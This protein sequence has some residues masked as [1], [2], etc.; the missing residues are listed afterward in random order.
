MEHRRLDDRPP[1]AAAG[2]VTDERARPAGAGVPGDTYVAGPAPGSPAAD[3]PDPVPDTAPDPMPAANPMPAADEGRDATGAGFPSRTSPATPDTLFDPAEAERFRERW[4]EVQSAF[5]D[6]PGDSV[7]RAD[8]L[9]SDAVESLGRAI[10]ARRRT[11][12]EELQDG[13]HGD[14][15]RLRQALRGYRDL[16]DRVFAS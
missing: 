13:G 16:L 11:L 4:R 7:R 15:E 2:P 12:S 9:A 8:E 3:A 10:T 14:T 6:D 1:G 5:V